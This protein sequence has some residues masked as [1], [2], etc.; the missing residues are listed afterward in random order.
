MNHMGIAQ[1]E[2]DPLTNVPLITIIQVEFKNSAS[3]QKLNVLYDLMPRPG[4]KKGTVKFLY[5]SAI[6]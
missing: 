1:N 4:K 6:F 3:I 5:T 2:P